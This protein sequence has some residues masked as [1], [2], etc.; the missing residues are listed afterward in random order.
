ME[1]NCYGLEAN[2]EQ[3]GTFCALPHTLQCSYKTTKPQVGTKPKQVAIPAPRSVPARMSLSLRGY[4]SCTAMA[5]T[6]PAQQAS[7]R[8]VLRLGRE[9]KAKQLCMQRKQIL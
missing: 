9:R 7:L 1:T 8:S 3:P 6:T 4:L 5:A 2:E